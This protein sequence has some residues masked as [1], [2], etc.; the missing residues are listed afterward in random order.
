MVGSDLAQSLREFRVAVVKTS[1]NDACP[2][3]IE[4][5]PTYA[6]LFGTI[7]A[8]ADG[9]SGGR[10]HV[11]P[12]ALLRADGG[13]LVLRCLDVLSEPGVWKQLKRTLQTG[14]LEIREFDQASGNQHSGLQPE[15]IPI[16][17]K[18]VLIGEP[19]VYEQL[20]IEDPQFPQIFKIHAEFDARSRSPRRTSRATPTTCSGW[21]A[22]E[23]LLPFAGDAMA[24]IA[25]YGARAPA[26]AIA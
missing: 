26:A 3:V 20:A 6:N 25:E 5:N 19:G 4:T 17:L 2:V 24:A 10:A 22:R 14:K 21:S 13:Y 8:P 11:H 9:T 23:T 12:G 16:D 1:L 7:S 15:A 18:V